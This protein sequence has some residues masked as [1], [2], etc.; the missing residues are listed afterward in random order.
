MQVVNPPLDDGEV[1]GGKVSI[2]LRDESTHFQSLVLR[3]TVRI[4]PRSG[5]NDHAKGRN[6]SLRFRECRNDSTQQVTAD[7]GAAD[8]HH[9]DLFL[10]GIAKLLPQPFPVGE[11]GW[12]EASQITREGVVLTRP[13]PNQWQ[14]R[15]ERI[16]DD[17]GV[18][19]TTSWN[20]MKLE[21]K[22]SSIRRIA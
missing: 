13:V 12:I 14:L 17:V 2:E 20:T 3:E 18:L 21:S 22:I 11:V 19:A 6:L 1:A 9:A 10:I 7:T 16:G 4:D 5:D 8:G 15:P